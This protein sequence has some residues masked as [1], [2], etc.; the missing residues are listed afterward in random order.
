MCT[1]HDARRQ[2][3]AASASDHT[4]AAAAAAACAAKGEEVCD[5]HC[6]AVDEGFGGAGALAHT[7]NNHD[8]G[9]DDSDD[10]G[11]SY[12]DAVFEDVL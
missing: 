1:L 2:Q 12:G 10:D 6:V 4:A 9:D 3:D 7:I 8:R 11:S 5:L